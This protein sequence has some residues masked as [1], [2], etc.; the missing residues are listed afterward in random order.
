MLQDNNDK[1][2]TVVLTPLLYNF[3]T[4]RESMSLLDSFGYHVNNVSLPLFYPESK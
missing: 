4:D 3:L 1:H 2:T